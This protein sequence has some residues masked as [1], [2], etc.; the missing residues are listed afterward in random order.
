MFIQNNLDLN[1]VNKFVKFFTTIFLIKFNN[2]QKNLNRNDFIDYTNNNNHDTVHSCIILGIL[3][4][5]E[6]E[7]SIV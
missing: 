7:I 3:G 1:Y 5:Y 2:A 4:H 6:L